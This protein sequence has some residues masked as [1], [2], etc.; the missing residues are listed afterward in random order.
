M[1]MSSG[2]ANNQSNTD[3]TNAVANRNTEKKIRNKELDALRTR[4]RI[5]GVP[6]VPFYKDGTIKDS[7]EDKYLVKKPPTA[8][9][10]E[11]LKSLTDLYTEERLAELGISEKELEAFREVHN[12]GNNQNPD[13]DLENVTST[14]HPGLT[15]N[16]SIQYD[17]LN[18][19]IPIVMGSIDD[20][21]KEIKTIEAKWLIKNHTDSIE[22]TEEYQVD[23]KVIA[24][25][26]ESIKKLT[27]ELGV[28][29]QGHIKLNKKIDAYSKS[30]REHSKNES[31]QKVLDAIRVTEEQSHAD[32]T[33][34][35]AT[36]IEIKKLRK[37][38]EESRKGTEEIS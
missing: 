20:I 17:W 14:S 22:A 9:Q 12:P 38:Y 18:K 24:K 36:D 37:M 3:P 13:E 10:K 30:Q 27:K 4:M 31:K 1:N 16:E 11:Q 21:Q 28:F 2:P 26:D 5:D 34:E 19:I 8:T 25:L 6:N 23:S 7:K 35:T 33:G 32:L 15:I 29:R